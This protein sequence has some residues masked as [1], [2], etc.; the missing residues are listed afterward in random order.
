MRHDWLAWITG[1]IVCDSPSKA[2]PFMRRFGAVRSSGLRVQVLFGLGWTVF[3]AGCA[4][5]ALAAADY[6]WELPLRVRATGLCIAVA[7]TLLV[8]IVGSVLAVL[9]WSRPRTARELESQFPQLGQ[10]VRTVVQFS[11]HDPEEVLRE[12]VRPDLVAA[13][14]EET[15]QC[16]QP[17]D[18]RAI[19]PRRRTAC[20][21]FLALIPVALILGG[22][23]A[24]LAVAHWRSSAP[25]SATVRTRHWQSHPATCVI[26]QGDEITLSAVSQRQSPTPGH[27]LDAQRRRTGRTLATRGAQQSIVSVTVRRTIDSWSMRSR[28]TR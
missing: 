24:G 25:C 26:N 8:A 9:R 4:L 11:G 1:T 12:G 20:A 17:L 5:L 7:L 27:A 22:V 16:A 13:L 28:C 6:T 14:E 21:A 19:V 18:V 23:L 2:T 15:D 3:V 10:R